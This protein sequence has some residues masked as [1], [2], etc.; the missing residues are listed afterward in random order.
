M[1]KPQGSTCTFVGHTQ[2]KDE[3][4]TFDSLKKLFPSGNA[5]RDLKI[6]ADEARA[7]YHVE[8][9][10]WIY[11]DGASKQESP[12]PAPQ[13]APPH[14]WPVTPYFQEQDRKCAYNAVKNV[15]YDLPAELELKDLSFIIN[16][17]VKNN[18]AKVHTYFILP[19]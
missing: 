18:R 10:R 9:L 15:G 19:V 7:A 11:I 13:L 6:R 1:F 5:R 8:D 4:H 17:L 16:F 12:V 3:T 2:S 14:A